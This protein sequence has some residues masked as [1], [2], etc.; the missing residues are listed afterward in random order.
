MQCRINKQKWI[1]HNYH[2]CDN[3]IDRYQTA[4]LYPNWIKCCLCMRGL[5]TLRFQVSF[6]LYYIY[7]LDHMQVL[8][9]PLKLTPFDMF[10]KD[11]FT[12]YRPLE[13]SRIPI[14]KPGQVR[15]NGL[16]WL[17]QANQR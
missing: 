2:K 4:S 15:S 17:S 3:V 16:P 5:S 11:H 12:R 8:K 1:E 7:E 14:A 10:P 9:F 6:I 13:L